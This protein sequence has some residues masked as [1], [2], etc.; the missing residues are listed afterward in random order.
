MELFKKI[1][2]KKT[3]AFLNKEEGATLPTFDMKLH[4]LMRV[5]DG[6][7]VKIHAHRADDIMTAVRISKE[8]ISLVLISLMSP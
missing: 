1:E 8:G 6:M 5:F 4:S 3:Q 7:I 2:N